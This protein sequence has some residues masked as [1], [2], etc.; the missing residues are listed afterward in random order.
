[1]KNDAS[2]RDLFRLGL[3]LPVAGIAFPSLGSAAAPAPF[4]TLGKTGLKV[5][6][7][8][9][10]CGFTPDPT[11][12]ARAMDLGVNL[13]DTANDYSNGNSE[14]VLAEG[15]KGRRD[16]AIVISKTPAR[17][18][19]QAVADLE[20]SLKNLH[21]DHIDVWLLHAKNTPQ[22]VSG[23]LVEHGEAAK[24]QGKIRYFG[25][26]T[27]DI[28]QMVDHAIQ[29]KLDVIEFSYNFTM[30]TSKDAA[31]EKARQAGIGLAAIKVMAATGGAPRRGNA[32]GTQGGTAPVRPAR[33]KNPLAA[34]K[35]VVRNP[36]I[37][38]AL[39]GTA[40][41]DMLEANLKA[42]TEGFT[43]EDENALVARN[44][45][46]RPYYCRMCFQCTGQCPKGLPVADELRILAY[47]DFYNDFVRARTHFLRL[48]QD[49]QAIRCSDCSVCAVRC[50]NGVHVAQRLIRAQEML[51]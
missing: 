41:S 28:N 38:A 50:P 5:A 31:I 46:V 4:K 42:L 47:A 20:S 30:G 26:S 21:T 15:L 9:F 51:A 23:E 25:V 18:K 33:S 16:K 2:R 12:I 11:V 44:E 39:P 14:R 10:G 7:V 49:T 35:W 48:P 40:D 32:A 17:N 19:A 27:H 13:F 45:E 36:A 43:P 34:L 37:A 3:S 6:P 8:G 1:M 22:D 29:S 24:K